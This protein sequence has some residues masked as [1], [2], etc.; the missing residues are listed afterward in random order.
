MTKQEVIRMLSA[1]EDHEEVFALV[2]T[3][4]NYQLHAGF[5]F[6]G[7]DEVCPKKVDPPK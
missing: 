4:G 5:D 1:L 7:S 6:R 3:T 2:G